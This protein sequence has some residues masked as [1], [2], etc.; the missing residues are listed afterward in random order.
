MN[1]LENIA[2][3]LRLSVVLSVVLVLIGLAAGHAGS[4]YGDDITWLAILVI[5]LSPFA[6]IVAA[7]ASLA[8]EKDYRWG[9]VGLVLIMI[10]LV[11]MTIAWIG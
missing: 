11:G 9:A 2:R 1:L 7:T 8:L 3:T 4:P 10:S 5:I 6:G